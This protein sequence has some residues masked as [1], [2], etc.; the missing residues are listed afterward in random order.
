MAPLIDSGAPARAYVVYARDGEA[1]S[2]RALVVGT[3]AAPWHE[4][5][6]RR[7]VSEALDA[8]PDGEA[9]IHRRALKRAERSADRQATMRARRLRQVAE[10]LMQ[11]PFETELPAVGTHCDQDTLARALG[12]SQS[13][14]VRLAA[15]A[16]IPIGRYCSRRTG[17]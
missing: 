5:Y 10:F 16:G 13:T 11:V 6:M 14:F 3:P 15:G 4:R 8:V 1:R 12:C 17:S 2:C 9:R 7:V